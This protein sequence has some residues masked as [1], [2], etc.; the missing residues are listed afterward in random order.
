MCEYFVD[1]GGCDRECGEVLMWTVK[2]WTQA[3]H[4]SGETQRG[5]MR[6]A[7]CQPPSSAWPHVPIHGAESLM[8][9]F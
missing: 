3:R 4:T 5:T 2:R 8:L 9:K 1:L 6:W 7:V